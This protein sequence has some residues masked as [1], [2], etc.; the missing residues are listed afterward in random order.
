MDSDD[1][2]CIR[3]GN[4]SDVWREARWASSCRLSEGP[5]L[6]SRL[7]ERRAESDFS[8]QRISFKELRRWELDRSDGLLKLRHDS[9]RFFSVEGLRVTTNFGPEPEWDQAI[10]RQNEC[11]LL[12]IAA[13]IR[14]RVLEFLMQA[15]TEPGAVNAVQ[16][17]PTIQA[18]RSNFTRV[19]HGRSPEYYELFA[20]YGAPGRWISRLPQIEQTSRFLGK[21]N[22]IAIL[23]L[24]EEHQIVDC[25]NFL[26]CTLRDLKEL[27]LVNNNLNMNTCSV[28]SCI[29]SMAGV[30]SSGAQF[31]SGSPAAA[32]LLERL[33]SSL[34]LSESNLDRRREPLSIGE[35][36]AWFYEMRERYRISAESRGIDEL[37]GWSLSEDGLSSDYFSVIGVRVKASREV[38]EWDQ[39]LIAQSEP[40]LSVLVGKSIDDEPCFLFQAKCDVGGN[41]AVHLAPTV[42]CS[43]P[44]RRRGTKE[45]PPFLD[46]VMNIPDDSFAFNVT[47]SEEGGRFHHYYIDY[48]I[49]WDEDFPEHDIPVNFQWIPYR[50]VFELMRHGCLNIEARGLFGFLV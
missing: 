17:S 13:R 46:D 42:S 16:L 21:R 20:E 48:K 45:A 19:H 44:S 43:I 24:P 37:E 40:G 8:V 3:R 33:Y 11:G 1:T 32:S 34:G 22:I 29:P 27:Y 9:G 14:E 49:L 26:W 2:Q 6:Q 10:I 38:G 36:M 28:L 12:G 50:A 47:L 25:E 30:P 18:T 41:P 35:I 39:P 23:L 31:I 15:K 5:S 7:D 4:A